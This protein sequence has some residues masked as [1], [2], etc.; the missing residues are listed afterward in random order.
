MGLKVTGICGGGVIEVNKRV[1][2]EAYG[3]SCEL[4]GWDKAPCDIHHIDYQE[5]MIL[6]ENIK[7]SSG[8]E[9]TELLELAKSLGFERFRNGRL[10]KNN[11]LENLVVVCPNCHRE[12]HESDMGKE[13]LEFLPPRKK[14]HNH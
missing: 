13:I 11:S 1:A 5:H 2:R 3:A 4:C 8:K 6:Q 14:Q 10:S 7:H 12:I 9:R